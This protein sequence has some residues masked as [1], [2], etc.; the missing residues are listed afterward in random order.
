MGA[1]EH[2]SLGEKPIG[3]TLVILGEIGPFELFACHADTSPLS[4]RAQR[5]EDPESRQKL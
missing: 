4:F 1:W 2:G 3:D 5:S